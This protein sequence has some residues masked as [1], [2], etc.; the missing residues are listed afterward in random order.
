[1]TSPDPL[2]QAL[3]SAAVAVVRPGD[4]LVLSFPQK[5]SEQ[6]ADDMAR[7][8]KANMPEGVR[9]C[10]VDQCSGMAVVRPDRDV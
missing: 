8:F 10:F 9:V 3:T 7:Q 4:T 2:V 1:M 5:L 6:Q